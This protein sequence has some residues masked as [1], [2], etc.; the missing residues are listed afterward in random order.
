MTRSKSQSQSSKILKQ[1]TDLWH[2]KLISGL[3]QVVSC[4]FWLFFVFHICRSSLFENDRFNFTFYKCYY[5]RKILNRYL[6]G[7][8]FNAFLSTYIKMRRFRRWLSHQVCDI[9]DKVRRKIVTW[10]S[11]FHFIYLLLIY[12]FLVFN[13]IIYS[14]LSLRTTTTYECNEWHVSSAQAE[15]IEGATAFSIARSGY[16]FSCS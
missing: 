12:L 11:P 1:W 5:K 2:S 8:G 10:V 3:K 4:S 6:I 7:D 16:N 15:K 13:L 14:N 9:A